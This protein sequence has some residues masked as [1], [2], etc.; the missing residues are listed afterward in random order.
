M[1]LLLNIDVPD[2]APAVAFYTAA[3]G[4]RLERIIGDDIAELSGAGATICL[5]RKAADSPPVGSRPLVRRYDRHWTPVH[6]DFIV[7]DVMEAARRALAAGAT[8]ESECIV[9]N[10]SRCITFSDPFGHGFCLIDFENEGYGPGGPVRVVPF[11]AA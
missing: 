2:L 4:L 6:I 10:D 1:K 8:R 7:D 11:P 5:L 9:W 3:L